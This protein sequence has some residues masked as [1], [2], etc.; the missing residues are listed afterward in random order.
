M[1]PK[2]AVVIPCYNTSAACVDVIVN[3]RRFAD[4]VLA[5]DDGSTDDTLEHIRATGCR[6]VALARNAGKGAALKAGIEATLGQLGGAPR[7][8]FDFLL[9][10]DGDGQHDPAD[11]PRFVNRAVST[12]AD[13]VIGVRDPR[14]MPRKSRVG[15]HY[16]RLLFVIG[17]GR[18][19]AETQSGYR[20][21]SARLIADLLDRV[22][23]T[24]YETES[25]ILGRT[26]EQG[27]G[28]SSVEISTIYFDGNRRSTF[29]AWRDSARIASVFRRQI[30][31]TVSAAA[32][33]FLTFA[34]I[35]STT[36][37]RTLVHA[38]AANVL[39]RFAA[40]AFQVVFRRD[41]VRRIRALVREEGLG[42][43]AAALFGHLALTTLLL[44]A[45]MGVG[46]H[47]ALAKAL[48]QLAG[49]LTSFAIVDRLLFGKRLA[50][51]G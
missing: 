45:L 37:S 6:H 15:N 41:F 4:A 20:L 26:I 32:F 19:I 49:Y 14:A 47:S 35:M 7:P 3:A 10:I 33:D 21:F 22:T 8:P 11:I 43:C 13:L 34:A 17:T 50:V 46:F 39:S 38:A 44:V 5:V 12:G 31:W 28:I 1:A 25:E 2:T 16:S 51:L 40:L 9:T 27:F 23:W 36:W 42:W 24:R 18:Y 30:E 29:D 48:A